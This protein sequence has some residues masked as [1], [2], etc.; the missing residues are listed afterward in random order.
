MAGITALV[1]AFRSLVS[2]GSNMMD[3]TSQFEQTEKGLETVLQSAVKGKAL[4]EDLRKYSFDTT[5][6]VD[7]LASASTQLLNAGVATKELKKDLGMIGDLAK[8]N[9]GIFQELSAIYA[10]ILNQGKASA[11]QINQFNIRGVPLKK[12]LTELGVTG[13]AT[14]EDI[15]RAFEKLTG[16]GGQFHNAMSTI[17]DTI[18]GKR[19]FITDTIKEINV[20]FGELSGLTDAYKNTLDIVYNILNSVNDKLREWNEN[21]V[22]KAI[23]SGAFA[24]ALTLLVS[25]IGISLVK[26][27]MSVV[28][29]LQ[30]IATL[31]A[32]M[33]DITGIIALVASGIVGVVAGVNAFSSAQKELADKT[34]EAT[35]ALLE[36]SKA[37][38]LGDSEAYINSIVSEKQKELE[39]KQKELES[40]NVMG[41]EKTFL[42][43]RISVLKEEIEDFKKV[44]GNFKTKREGESLLETILGEINA[45]DPKI[46]A[47][48]EQIK[49]L[50]EYKSLKDA[51]NYD[52]LSEEQKNNV[53]K[54]INY[55]E[56]KIKELEKGTKET[57]KTWQE[58]WKEVTG[59]TVGNG[60]KSGYFAGVDYKNK[61]LSDMGIDKTLNDMLGGGVEGQ[62]KI[63]ENYIS[64]IEGSIATLLKEKNIDEPFTQADDSIKVLIGTLQYLKSELKGLSDED[65]ANIKVITSLKDI[66]NTWIDSAFDENGLYNGNG[67]YYL[68][69]VAVGAMDSN[70]GN[71]DAGVFINDLAKGMPVLIALLDVLVRDIFDVVGGFEGINTILSPIKQTIQELSPI[72]K[73][74]LL[75]LTMVSQGL[76]KLLKLITDS[77]WWNDFEDSVDEA[78]S[79]FIGETDK[80]K[81]NLKALNE[82]YKTLID[83]QKEQE[84]YYIRTK[85]DINSD[86]YRD[87]IYNV[88]D[89]ILTP[90]GTFSTSPQDY[91]IATKNPQSLGGGGD[92]NIK[93]IDNA[94]VNVEASRDNSTGEILVTISQKI[95]SDV[96]RGVNGWDNALRVREAR[97]SGISRR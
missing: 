43:N 45:K 77:S 6:G 92:V 69:G 10:K 51:F 24:T 13:V 72:L 9:K 38:K 62:K 14:A 22:M 3:I 78:W 50:K 79:G 63:L 96:A 76:V 80:A 39:E 85:K 2:V 30:L 57:K 40:V 27:L 56:E 5:F 4:F 23:I 83:I 68:K 11:M 12:T 8:G 97:I 16:E 1:G 35:I 26:A 71:S 7:E 64:T 47:I 73:L 84:E 82:Q 55:L 93:I 31:K 66:S 90:Q 44:L 89:M 41:F 53:D 20:N 46:I 34:D 36:Q 88:N 58:F 91:L 48:E 21:P 15:T 86:S 70:F 25:I 49:T 19:G 28:T 65:I 67:K 75:G 59:I 17:I 81:E 32:S 42:Q 94:G 87:R 33:G 52:V 61:L 60:S 74:I 37:L 18:E 29:Q 95:A 54:A